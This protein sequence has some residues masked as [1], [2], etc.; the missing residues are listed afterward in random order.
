MIVPSGSF[1][2]GVLRTELR[3]FVERHESG[4]RQQSRHVGPILRPSVATP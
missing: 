1:G 2:N 4:L 3:H